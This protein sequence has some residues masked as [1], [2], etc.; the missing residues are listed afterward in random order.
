MDGLGQNL[1]S[2]FIEQN[3][4]FSRISIFNLGIALINIFE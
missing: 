2:Y 1:A 4:S 3:K